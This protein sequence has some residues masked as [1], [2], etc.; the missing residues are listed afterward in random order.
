[1]TRA[2][3]VRRTAV[4]YGVLGL[5]VAA[6][7]YPIWA[8]TIGAF[9]GVLISVVLGAGVVAL[10]HHQ[11]DASALRAMGATPLDDGRYPR[12]DNMVEGLTVA[13]GFRVPAVHVVEDAAPNAAVLARTP[14][15]GVLVLTTGLIDRLDRVQLESVLAH[16]LMRIRSGEAMANLTAAALP[17]RLAGV[18]AGPASRL[19]TMITEG[20]VVIEADRAAT[21]I[22]RYPPGLEGALASIHADGRTVANNSRA[23]RHLWL[24]VPADAVVTS[25]FDLGDRIAV[26]QEL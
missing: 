25:T 10:V 13:H 26:L 22:T 19:A 3:A 7:T 11:S 20:A 21:E 5:L 4:A 23:H 24:D 9:W 12:L 18:A 17:G 14:R 2:L 1:M 16:E 6:A 15:N 8:F